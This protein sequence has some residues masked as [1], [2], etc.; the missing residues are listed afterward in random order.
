M[1]PVLLAGSRPIS[2]ALFNNVKIFNAQGELNATNGRDAFKILASLMEQM[3]KG[4]VFAETAANDEPEYTPQQ[5]R[6][7]LTAAFHD[8]DRSVWSE[9][10][11]TI[12]GKLY[13]QADREGFA[14]NLLLRGEVGQGQRPRFQVRT[15][16]AVAV[17]AVGPVQTSF[18]LVR[19]K[20]IE[21]DE[22]QVKAN[23][24]V[25]T[26]DLNQGQGDLLDNAYMDAL[27]Q[28][29]RAEDQTLI[30]MLR[31]AASAAAAN[32][33]TYLAGP[34]SNLYLGEQKEALDS[35]NITAAV[36]LMASDIMNDIV[37]QGAFPDNFFDPV[38]KLEIVQTGRLGSVFG[39][40]LI[41]DAHRNPKLRC[42]NKGEVFALGA[43]EQLGGYTD[44]G[45]VTSEPTGP[46]NT[47]GQSGK[48]WYMEESISMIVHNSRAVSYAKRL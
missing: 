4:E 20:Y 14:R 32:A 34:Y 17:R 8:N 7:I 25:F 23:P 16:D 35:W 28:I 39:L 18:S 6:E 15:K 46:T 11:A 5:K 38:T 42:L 47:T 33:T 1:K 48:G 29:F 43:P 24:Y 19:D 36:L 44:R 9:I 13:E 27:E 41:T 10:G 2:D 26:N 3:S 30:A 31:Q 21:V 37:T 12:A 22:F 45:P 40:Q